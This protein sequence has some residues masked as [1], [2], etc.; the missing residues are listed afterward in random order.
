M[1]NK[2]LENEIGKI[3]K[4]IKH[5]QDIINLVTDIMV[6]VGTELDS[7]AKKFKI[8]DVVNFKKSLAQ[9][10]TVSMLDDIT[11]SCEIGKENDKELL[12]LFKKYIEKGSLLNKMHL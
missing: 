8:V 12:E 7:I 6:E 3:D 11:N 9:R 5:N 4:E 2:V 10:I 1:K